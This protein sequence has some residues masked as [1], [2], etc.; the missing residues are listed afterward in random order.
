MLAFL[1]ALERVGTHPGYLDGAIEAGER[2]AIEEIEA[3][4][5]TGWT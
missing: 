5:R 1:K 2:A 3:L 4:A